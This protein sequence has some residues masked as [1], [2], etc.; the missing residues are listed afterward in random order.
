MRRELDGRVESVRPRIVDLEALHGGQVQ[1][2]AFRLRDR[3]PALR[4]PRRVGEHIDPVHEQERP[5]SDAH[6]SPVGE[7][8]QTRG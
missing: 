5:A 8:G 1:L 2:E 4:D 6:V 3:P 7:D